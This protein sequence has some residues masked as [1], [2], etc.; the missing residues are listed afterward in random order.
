M[1][2]NNKKVKLIH[3]LVGTKDLTEW[4]TEFVESVWEKSEEARNTG[5]LTGKQIV[6]VERIYKK[7]FG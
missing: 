7:N 1:A 3:G 5:N 6:V 4:E 2:S